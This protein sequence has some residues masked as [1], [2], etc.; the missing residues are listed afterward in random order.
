MWYKTWLNFEP[1]KLKTTVRW[2]EHVSTIVPVRAVF[3][4]HAEVRSTFCFPMLLNCSGQKW[5][6]REQDPTSWC[7]QRR[8]DQLVRTSW[9]F[10]R[11]G[12]QVVRTSW[13]FLQTGEQ[14]VRTSWCFQ[15]TRDQV[16]QTSG[17]FYWTG[18][19]AIQA[20]AIFFRTAKNGCEP[21]SV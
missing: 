21:N 11:T 19:Q 8:N 3:N 18:D 1:S 20:D 9:C 14:V 12:A 10:R 17:S 7:C 5:F 4:F 6:L 15:Q 16:I 13:C 2:D